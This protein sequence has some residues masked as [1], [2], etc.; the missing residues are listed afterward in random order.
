M[1]RKLIFLLLAVSLLTPWPVVYAYDDVLAGNTTVQIEAAESGAAPELNG[2]GNAIGSVTPGDLFYI[3]SGDVTLD[4]QFILYITNTDELVHYYRYITLNVGVYAQTGTD[5]WEKLT[6]GEGEPHDT[7]ITMNNGYVN[8]TLPGYA[9]YK[10][11]ID[12]GCF[13]CYGTGTGKSAV[14]PKFYLTTG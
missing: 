7:Y 2:F 9:R 10:I 14:M 13:Y 6:T 11:T 4:T 12:K 1:K 8:F 3:D 5:Q